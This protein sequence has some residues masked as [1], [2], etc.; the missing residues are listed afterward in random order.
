MM[1]SASVPL[2]SR[3]SFLSVYARFVDHASLEDQGD[4]AEQGDSVI[5]APLAYCGASGCSEPAAAESQLQRQLLMLFFWLRVSSWPFTYELILVVSLFI[6]IL[7]LK[8]Y[9]HAF[10]SSTC[11][12]TARTR[13]FGHVCK[14]RRKNA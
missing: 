1:G 8:I 13:H 3:R 14:L 12:S 6:L 11:L 4:Y 9:V 2:I 5:V 10:D 7:E